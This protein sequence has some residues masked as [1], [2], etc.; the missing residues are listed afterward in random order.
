[1]KNF[2]TER[3]TKHWKMLSRKVAESL[4]LEIF[5]RHVDVVLRGHG[6]VMDL[7][8]LVNG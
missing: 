6:L 5:K 8:V 3:V 4:L 2:F 1:M 7:S